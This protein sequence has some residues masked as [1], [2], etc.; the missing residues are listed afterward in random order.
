MRKLPPPSRLRL[1]ADR[2]RLDQEM[3]RGGMGAVWVAEDEKLKRKVAVKIMSGEL[4]QKEQ[5]RKRFE[6]EATT[7]ASLDS[8]H[9]VQIFDYGIHGSDPYIVMELLDGETLLARCQQ[10]GELCPKHV[11]VLLQDL[12]RTLATVH[13][14]GII[15]RDLKPDNIFLAKQHGNI[16]PKVLD[17]GIAKVL[18][19][20]ALLA[21]SH[22]THTRT[23]SVLGTPHYMSFEQAMSEETIDHRADIWSFGVIMF[24]LL[25]GRRPLSFNSLG[26]MY[27]Q[28]LQEE[29]PSLGECAPDVP[30][31]V[32]EL[33]DRSLI[34]D[35]DQRL[36]D[37]AEWV[38]ILREL[39]PSA[40]QSVRSR[41]VP[42]APRRSWPKRYAL[43]GTAAGLIVG[44]TTHLYMRGRAEPSLRIVTSSR[45]AANTNTVVGANA[46]VDPNAAATPEQAPVTTPGRVPSASSALRRIETKPSPTGLVAKSSASASHTTASAAPTESD[47]APPRPRKLIVDDPYGAPPSP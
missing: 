36:N 4:A 23:G 5:A 34:K 15:H 22:E 46:P 10:Q 43:V 42:Q 32:R 44:A 8:A 13:Q 47:E 7:A 28:L 16:V 11:L 12:A 40:P 37:M 20:S 9:V 39:A 17:F 19:A 24:E 29:L 31:V 45:A 2:Y 14:A 27:S 30:A 1:I 21:E 25:S 18:D 35:R 38:A 3:A 26:Q 6:R 41:E 33:V